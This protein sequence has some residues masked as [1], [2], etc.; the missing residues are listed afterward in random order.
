MTEKQWLEKVQEN[1]AVLLAFVNDWH[2]TRLRERPRLPKPMP[3]T[4]PNAE[5]SRQLCVASIL[6]EDEDPMSIPQRWQRAT[7]LKDTNEFYS[8]MNAAWMGVPES[9]SCWNIEGFS[10]AANLLSDPP[11]D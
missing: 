9:T 3:I 11:E 1:S 6:K 8:L 2:P 4:A 7:D 10:M 5:N